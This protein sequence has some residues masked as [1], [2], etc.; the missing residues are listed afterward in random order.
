MHFNSTNLHLIPECL[1]L[2]CSFCIQ[3]SHFSEFFFYVDISRVSRFFSFFSKTLWSLQHNCFVCFMLSEAAEWNRVECTFDKSLTSLLKQNERNFHFACIIYE[4]INIKDEMLRK[5]HK[6]AINYLK[7]WNIDL[8]LKNQLRFR[9]FIDV[10]FIVSTVLPSAEYRLWR[11]EALSTMLQT[12]LANWQ[13]FE[14]ISVPSFWGL[15][16]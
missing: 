13:N 3:L 15:K 14:Q 12:S 5:L 16:L 10:W 2:H 11:V 9:D 7:Q 4:K 1:T 6:H 8:E